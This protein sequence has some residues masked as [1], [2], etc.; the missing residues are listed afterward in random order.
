MV[1][2]CICFGLLLVFILTGIACDIQPQGEMARLSMFIGV[3]IS[4]SFVKGEYFDD[5]IDF[6]AHYIYAHLQGLGGLE[7]PNVLFVGSIGGATADEPKT[8]YPIHTFE[9]KSVEEIAIKLREIFPEEEVNPFTDYNA[10]FEQI[11]QMVKNQNLLMRPVSVV[12]ISDGIPDIESGEQTDV[13]TLI[14]KPMERLARNVTIR[15]L[16][17]T[18][19]VGNQWQTQI[20]RQR[21]RVWTQDAKVMIAWKD[22]AIFKPDTPV[23]EQ[24][25]F[26]NW[27]K[28]NVDFP[29][30]PQRVN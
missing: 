10:F 30:R 12:M 7:K 16:Y 23:D 11:A 8:F 26:F 22:T 29:V 2:K 20:K 4:G 28:D 1:K 21:V 13:S 14:L 24:H 19:N 9:N 6:L 25:R 5:G 3:D 18:A 15:L 27:V 17:T